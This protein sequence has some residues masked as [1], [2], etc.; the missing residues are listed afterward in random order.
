M[1][2]PKDFINDIFI[3]FRLRDLSAHEKHEK[4][5]LMKDFE[6]KQSDFDQLLKCSEKLKSRIAEMEEQIDELHS[7]V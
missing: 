6:E 7:H 1:D 3:L 5:K 2:N 4:Q